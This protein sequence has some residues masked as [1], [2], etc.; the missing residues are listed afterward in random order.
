M[1]NQL[2]QILRQRNKELPYG[3]GQGAA[4]CGIKREQQ[5][6]DITATSWKGQTTR[7]PISSTVV[8]ILSKSSHEGRRHQGW[9]CGV[10]GATRKRGLLQQARAILQWGNLQG[11]SG[12]VGRSYWK[13]RE[14]GKCTRCQPTCYQERLA[15]RSSC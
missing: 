12:G 7:V 6:R 13:Q 9:G 15:T 8:C 3:R 1:W 11:L 10:S 2:R 14:G 5:L 4:R